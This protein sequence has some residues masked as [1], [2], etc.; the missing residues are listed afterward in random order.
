MTYLGIVKNIIRKSDIVLVVIDARMPEL[1]RNEQLERAITRMGKKF[2]LVLNKTDLISK[3]HFTFLKR[4]YP[5]G[6]FVAGPSNIGINRLR[7]AI[8]IAAKKAGIENPKIGVVGYPNVGKSAIINA[9]AHR[10]KARISPIAGTTRGVQIIRAGSLQILDSPGVFPYGDDELKLGI[11]AAKN[12]EEI[13]NPELVA[14]E[15]IKMFFASNLKG[16]EDFYGVKAKTGENDAYEAMLEI[17]KA[18]K[19]LLKGGIIDE[20]RTALQIIMDWQRGKLRI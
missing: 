14:C 9:L 7:T 2:F 5:H 12:P 18:R 15:I 1:S 8:L 4:K 3:E 17:G 19:F 11:L 10:A 6:F 13:K 16:L 20:R